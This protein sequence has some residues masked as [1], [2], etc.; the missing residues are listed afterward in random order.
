[1]NVAMEKVALGFSKDD[2]ISKNAI[3]ERHW[4]TRQILDRNVYKKSC[5]AVPFT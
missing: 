3:Y 5:K 2:C 4:L 1:M